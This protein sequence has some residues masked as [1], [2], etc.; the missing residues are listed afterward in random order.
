[1]TTSEQATADGQRQRT[2][3]TAIAALWPLVGISV[4]GYVLF[5]D[6]S[7]GLYAGLQTGIGAYLSV[8][9]LLSGALADEVDTTMVSPAAGTFHRGALGFALGPGGIV[10]FAVGMATDGD[11]LLG[12]A[13]GIAVALVGYVVLARVLPRPGD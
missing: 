2:I 7:L 1:M 5:E 4:V 6:P 13:G 11:V 3:I 8:D 9:Y 12:V 10:A